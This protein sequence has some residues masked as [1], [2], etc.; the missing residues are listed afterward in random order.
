[1]KKHDEQFEREY[2][3]DDIK[4]L[5]YYCVDESEAYCIEKDLKY[6]RDCWLFNRKNYELEDR[7]DEDSMP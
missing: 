7:Y 5:K 2:L 3:L 4:Y 1:M 6:D